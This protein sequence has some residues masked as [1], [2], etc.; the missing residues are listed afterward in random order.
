M[1]A[2]ITAVVAVTVIG[3]LCA[4]ML[5]VASTLFGVK[6]DEKFKRIREVLPGANCGACGYTGCDG[7][8]KALAEDPTIKTNLCTPGGDS[9][10]AKIAEVLGIEAADVIEKLAMVACTGNCV[11]SPNVAKF[12]GTLT[13]KAAKQVYGGPQACSFGCL[14]FGDCILACQYDA[15]HLVDGIAKVDRT[16]C[17]GCTL[18][19]KACPNNIIIMTDATNKVHVKCSNTEKGAIARKQCNRACI[20]CM[21]CQKTC[22]HDAIHVENNLARVDY[23]KCTNCGAC[24]E[25]CPT[26][27][28]R[29]LI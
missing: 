3:L 9:G 18:C 24:V 10:A 2:I 11:N 16:K 26:G 14:G 28:I 29:K 6:E 22:P 20:G 21:K 17:V 4:V 15:I 27:C 7:Y 5:V 1:T 25:A 8:A 13:C 19:S 12:E 23:S